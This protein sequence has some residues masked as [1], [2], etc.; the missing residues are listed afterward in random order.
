MDNGHVCYKCNKNFS[1]NSSLKR[2]LNK[3]IP[4]DKNSEYICNICLAN[5]KTKQNLN[6]HKNKK[7]NFKLNF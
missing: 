5:F 2:H 7:N 6:N 3:K 1:T 4:C